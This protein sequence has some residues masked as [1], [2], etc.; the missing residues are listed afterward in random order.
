MFSIDG[1]QSHFSTSASLC[2]VTSWSL[3]SV[4]K[5]QRSIY[6]TITAC[7]RLSGTVVVSGSRK[8]W[9]ACYSLL[10][11]TNFSHSQTL[12]LQWHSISSLPKCTLL[13]L[14]VSRALFASPGSADLIYCPPARDQ[15]LDLS[16]CNWKEG[17]NC[18]AMYA[19]TLSLTFVSAHDWNTGRFSRMCS[20]W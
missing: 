18:L 9:L 5:V 8:A 13:L 3:F 20:G 14:A 17:V 4:I 15:P 1:R 16:A 7:F 11:C 19:T 12:C 10:K 2:K 6:L